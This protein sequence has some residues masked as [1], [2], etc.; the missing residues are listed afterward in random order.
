MTLE[1]TETQKRICKLRHMREECCWNCLHLGKDQ[2]R[3]I[4][5]ENYTKATWYGNAQ[6]LSKLGTAWT[7]EAWICIKNHRA[8]P[9]DDHSRPFYCLSIEHLKRPFWM[10]SLNFSYR[11]K[12]GKSANLAKA[13]HLSCPGYFYATVSLL[14]CLFC[15]NVLYCFWYFSVELGILSLNIWIHLELFNEIWLP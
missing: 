11:Y 6:L 14:S 5:H 15:K 3:Q 4:W 13:L 9:S 2:P 12:Y 7:E 10:S 8:A 1:K